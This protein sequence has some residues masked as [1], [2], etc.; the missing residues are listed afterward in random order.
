MKA[1][2]DRQNM[3]ELMKEAAGVSENLKEFALDKEGNP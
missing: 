2:D 1:L 3:T